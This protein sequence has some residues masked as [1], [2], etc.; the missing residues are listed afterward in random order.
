MARRL[1]KHV[2][3]DISL[4][5]KG[6][7]HSLTWQFKDPHS[8]R[9]IIFDFAVYFEVLGEVVPA[10]LD[11]AKRLEG[12]E[13]RSVRARRAVLKYLFDFMK[14][15]Q[16]PR[17]LI[18]LTDEFL[19][20][21]VRARNLK[22]HAPGNVHGKLRAI[23]A[24]ALRIH[25]VG[26]HRVLDPFSAER[27][28]A[29]QIRAL[30]RHEVAVILSA[31]KTDIKAYWSD[32]KLSLSAA[33]P[34]NM[35]CIRQIAVK[36]GGVIPAITYGRSNPNH[37][38]RDAMR[39]LW[40]LKARER[41]AGRPYDTATFERWL[42]ATPDALLPFLIM[43]TYKLAGNVYA[44]LE[45]KRTLLSEVDDVMRGRRTRIE[46]YKARSRKTLSHTAKAEG[47]FSVPSL[48]KCVLEYTQPLVSLADKTICDRLWIAFARTGRGEGRPQTLKS[49]QDAIRRW[50]ERHDIRSS[51]G[52]LLVFSL[53]MLRTSRI[54][55]SYEKSGGDVLFANRVANHKQLS[56]T[57]GY[58]KGGRAVARDRIAIA[59]AQEALVEESSRQ[60][61]LPSRSLP[62]WDQPAVSFDR[63]CN[64]PN[65]PKYAKSFQ[66][67]PSWL[68]PL[69]DPNLVVPNDPEII[70]N[71]LRD[72]DELID[73]RE[74]IDLNR[75]KRLYETKLQIIES[76]ILPKL[77]PDTVRVAEQLA[78]SFS[79]RAR[80][81]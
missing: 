18:D 46:F 61:K 42:Y 33:A 50:C 43:I 67:C 15:H 14:E 56:T 59:E 31:A 66:E 1:K 7:D 65:D 74:R 44:V 3:F 21:V 72:R 63:D 16:S 53:D 71:L 52:S 12:P 80:L 30:P 25:G 38:S 13:S 45:A 62:H 34:A 17:E 54:N 24:E 27:S 39:E 81:L 36:N 70:A 60:T 28:N 55:D 49:S 10:L 58:L 4:P 8:G 79:T 32:Y 23:V 73:A 9:N 22:G 5:S 51:D 40:A 57:I 69:A 68:F 35:K 6:Y 2:P 77:D 75:F 48:I 37:N 20:R 26:L 19:I 11:A 29:T 64:D 41:R 76:D 78:R 47:M